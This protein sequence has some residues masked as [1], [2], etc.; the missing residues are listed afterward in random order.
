MDKLDIPSNFFCKSYVVYIYMEHL[1]TQ[2][3]NTITFVGYISVSRKYPTVTEN[4]FRIPDTIATRA[5]NPHFEF[6]RILPDLWRA[7]RQ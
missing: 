5:E 6:C 2:L 1:F 7:L 3:N 4:C